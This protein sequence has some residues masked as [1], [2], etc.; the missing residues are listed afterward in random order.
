MSQSTLT[1][2]E[3]AVPEESKSSEELFP[4]LNADAEA[5]SSPLLSM[6]EEEIK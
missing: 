2:P 4:P 6:Q 1:D 5:F 3:P